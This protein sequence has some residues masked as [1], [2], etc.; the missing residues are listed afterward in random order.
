V[1]PTRSIP[2]T[3]APLREKGDLGNGVTVRLSDI[4]QVDGEA[5]GPGEV[6]GP[7]LRV[8]IEV[9]N[10]TNNEVSM[11]LALANLY[12]GR[13][14]TPASPLSGPGLR[15]FPPMIAAGKAASARYVFGVPKQ[16]RNPLAVEFSYTVEAP[17]VIFEG[18][19]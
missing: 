2:S 15:T 5:R 18:N 3:R 12:Y 17:T 16:G 1:V 7:A 13:N 6:A 11:E 8:S 9:Q 19:L 10:S 4:Q 14:R